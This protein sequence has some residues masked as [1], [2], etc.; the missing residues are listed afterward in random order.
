MFRIDPLTGRVTTHGI[1]DAENKAITNGMVVLTIRAQEQDTSRNQQQG[2][3][4]A[5]VTLRVQ[6]LDLDDN[7]PQFNAQTFSGSIS[8]A[9]SAGDYIAIAGPGFIAV[10]DIDKEEIHNRFSIHIEK[11]GQPWNVI[12]PSLN[13]AQD[14]ATVLLMLAEDKALLG[15]SNSKLRFQIVARGVGATGRVSGG[16]SSTAADVELSVTSSP[17]GSLALQSNGDDFS[18]AENIIYVL[19]VLLVLSIS[20]TIFIACRTKGDKPATLPLFRRNSKYYVSKRGPNGGPPTLVEPET[21]GERGGQT[22]V[23][24]VVHSGEVEEGATEH[25]PTDVYEPYMS[26]RQNSTSNDAQPVA[27]ASVTDTA[28]N[29]RQN[30]VVSA[31]NRNRCDVTLLVNETDSLKRSS[32]SIL[33][34]G[35]GEI[36]I[37]DQRSTP[38]GNDNDVQESQATAQNALLSLLGNSYTANRCDVTSLKEAENACLETQRSNSESAEIQYANV[39]STAISVNVI[40]D[41]F[42]TSKETKPSCDVTPLDQSPNALGRGSADKLKLKNETQEQLPLNKHERKCDLVPLHVSGD[43]TEDVQNPSAACSFK[44]ESDSRNSSFSNKSTNDEALLIKPGHGKLDGLKAKQPKEPKENEASVQGKINVAF[45]DTVG[46]DGADFQTAK[47]KTINTRPLKKSSKDGLSEAPK[48]IFSTKPKSGVVSATSSKSPGTSLPQL[49]PKKVHLKSTKGAGNSPAQLSQPNVPPVALALPS[50]TGSPAL[51]EEYVVIINPV[52]EPY[53]APAQKTSPA[54]TTAGGLPQKNQVQK[55]CVGPSST[56][57]EKSPTENYMRKAKD[58]LSQVASSMINRGE[59]TGADSATSYG[60]KSVQI[61]DNNTLSSN[62][63]SSE[64]FTHL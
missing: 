56:L 9:A 23:E 55:G 43:K 38:A 58:L 3:T 14:H 19:L 33:N 32:G 35:P 20:I 26:H 22:D 52:Y 10:D 5:T 39:E 59:N 28:N 17:P 25:S 54:K 4:T 61:A 63:D 41:T 42:E 7:S 24:N 45:V 50:F 16:G 11:D 48:G 37:K 2:D 1:L 36:G 46:E 31:V 44:S 12:K 6:V 18:T 27:G 8:E 13:I 30:T 51:A 34:G 40:K 64:K 62:P 15:M 49:A 60:G 53:T 57:A 21:M 47:V 29:S